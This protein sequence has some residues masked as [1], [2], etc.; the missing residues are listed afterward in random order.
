MTTFAVALDTADTSMRARVQ[1][2]LASIPLRYRLSAEDTGLERVVVVSGQDH[3]WHR[4]LRTALETGARGGMVV[5]PGPADARDVRDLAALA[6]SVNALVGVEVGFAAHQS[7][8]R[9]MPGVREDVAAAEL[10]DSFVTFDSGSVVGAF[11][12]QRA[13]V[14]GIT[15][16]WDPFDLVHHTADQYVVVARAGELPLRLTGLRSTLEGDG[17]RVDLVGPRARW[18]VRIQGDELAR[19]AEI[20]RFDA[21]GAH[22]QPLLF[23]SARRG[24]WLALH[25]AL[26][27]GPALT[28]TLDNLGEDLEIV[29]QLGLDATSAWGT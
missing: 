8:Q 11:V 24:A 13:V 12:A 29:A 20:T 5:R 23:E 26:T 17:L 15:G 14:R 28:Y 27:G 16:P 9:A 18:C 3:D 2:G 22:A 25:A 10:L 1:R 4:R 6:T 19:P 21:D 7:W